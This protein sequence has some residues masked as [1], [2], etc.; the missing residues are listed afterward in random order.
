MTLN[1]QTAFESIKDP[2]V[3]RHKRHKLLDII[4]LSI[5]AVI[6]GAEGWEAI[7]QFGHDKQKWL[8]QWIGLENGI[9][10]HDCIARVISRLEPAAM[11]SCFVAWAQSFTAM[12]DGEVVAIDGKTARHS[13]NRADKL[14]AIHMVSAWASQAGV[15]LGQV[16]TDAKSNEISAIP[17]LLAMLELKGCIVTLD[18]MGCQTAIA[19]KITDKKADYV[20]AVKGNQP[21]LHAAIVDYFDT[22]L[23]TKQPPVCELQHC[24][25]SDKGHGRV[26]TRRAYLSTCLAT[27]PNVD[28]W[29]GL[30]SIAMI[31][32]ERWI[33]GE[34]T[35]ERRY[36][37]STLTSVA[38]VAG[39][40]RA[41]W[42]VENSLHWVLDVTF[43]EDDSRIRTGYAP[44]NF[45]LMRQVA[46]NLFKK[47][48]SNLSIKRKRFKAALND[49]YREKVV[50]AT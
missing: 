45:N 2:R 6:S 34:T 33:K 36:Y 13:Y 7:E 49:S 15:S 9:P 39:A 48:P 24:Q 4:I 31:E 35:R 50:F 37:I 32:S 3:E 12:S 28:N 29:A 27:L 22:A 43:R 23:A 19:E 26:E 21:S 44:E 11:Q 42:G 10:S 14:G 18:A 16:K 17:E 40:V 30:K 46:L 38:A 1:L 41:H 5:C 47:E 20:L 8:R 25:E